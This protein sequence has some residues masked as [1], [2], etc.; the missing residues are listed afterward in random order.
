MDN[1]KQIFEKYESSVRS[2]C[3]AFPSVFYKA[4]G[5]FLYD[6]ENKK[7]I[8]F[9]CGAGSVNYGHNND[10]IKSKMIQ[11]LENDGYMHA[12]DMMTEAKA[13][14]IEYFQENVLKP[15]GLDYKILFPNP[16][17]TNAIEAALKLAR[18]QTGRTDVWCLMGCFHG[19]TL[20]ALALTTDADSREG[21][22]VPLNN[23]VHIPAPYLIV[24][25]PRD[26]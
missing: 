16:T 8:D 24:L 1:K 14:F 25:W 7:Y 13:D 17:G 9:F 15:R 19:M 12:L 6:L 22:G 3:R 2:Y 23:V 20:G 10:Y 11:F 26:S 18:K 5:P 21:A 4:K